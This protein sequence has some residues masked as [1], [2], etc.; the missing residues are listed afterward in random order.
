MN[1]KELD[2]QTAL[3][4]KAAIVALKARHGIIETAPAGWFTMR[5]IA[6]MMGKQLRVAQTEM[7]PWVD[8]GKVEVRHFRALTGAFNKSI[9]H[10]RL[11]EELVKAYGL[12]MKG[13]RK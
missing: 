3:R 11:D 4:R 2:R 12:K 13:G 9:P 10:Y 8:M 7:Q 5:D 6:K 1:T